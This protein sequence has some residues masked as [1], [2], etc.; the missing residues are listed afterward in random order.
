[1]IDVAVI[2]NLASQFGVDPA[3]AIATA[4]QESGFDPK[5]IGDGGHSIGL[6]QENDFGAGAGMTFA[7]RADP[8]GSVQRFAQR[9]KD[10]IASGFTGTPG[11]IA[12][13][14]QRPLDSVGYAASVDSLYGQY[15]TGVT[16]GQGT[17]G[18]GSTTS[19]GD[20]CGLDSLSNLV[21]VGRLKA[22]ESAAAISADM[23]ARLG[24]PITVDCINNANT[25][26]PPSTAGDIVGGVL[27]G[28]GGSLAPLV[29]PIALIVVV[30]VIVSIGLKD[31][32]D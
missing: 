3:L 18:G 19:S 32:A 21:I 4:K 8:V 31:I 1:M 7:Q 27:G 5:A 11:Q 14:A 23:T 22:G 12:A 17:A 16:G 30:L 2:S 13:A 6:Y 24:R 26:L 29:A 9:V 25:N 20:H 15:A 10:V 28:I